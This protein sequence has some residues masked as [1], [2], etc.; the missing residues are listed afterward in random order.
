MS[1]PM[2]IYTQV[3]MGFT[4]KGLN[5]KFGKT[6]EIGKQNQGGMNLVEIKGLAGDSLG[7]R[8]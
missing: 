2:A 1:D 3:G 6:Y 5:F 7:W 8:R 4:D